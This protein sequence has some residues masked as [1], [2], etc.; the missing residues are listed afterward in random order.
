M[1]RI[2]F[3]GY[4]DFADRMKVSSLKMELERQGYECFIIKQPCY[5]LPIGE[6]IVQSE[7]N[8]STVISDEKLP[9]PFILFCSMDGERLDM[10]LDICKGHTRAVITPFNSKMT[11]YELSKH[12]LE[13]KNARR[14]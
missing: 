9:E 2:F 14:R 10:A 5:V 1:I 4:T 6:I 3:F 7:K 11:A 13:E 12:L 8:V